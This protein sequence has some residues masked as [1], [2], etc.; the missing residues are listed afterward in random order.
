MIIEGVEVGMLGAY[1]KATNSESVDKCVDVAVTSTGHRVVRHSTRG[2][3]AIPFD[4]G[5]W[6]AFVTG[7]K[8]GEF[9]V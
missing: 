7:V 9:D 1:S 3:A 5:E 6:A 8:A 4:Q 2:G